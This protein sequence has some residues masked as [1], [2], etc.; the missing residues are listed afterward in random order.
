MVKIGIIGGSGLD[1]PKI[2]KETKELTFN[3]NYGQPSSPITTGKIRDVEVMILA[4]H[5]KKHTIMPTN[6]V[7]R[8]LYIVYICSYTHEGYIRNHD[9]L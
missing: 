4:R 1:N 6:D 2:L 8:N 9:G 5:G 7:N 3:T